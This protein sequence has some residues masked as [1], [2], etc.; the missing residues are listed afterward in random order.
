[1]PVQLLFMVY[2]LPMVVLV[3]TKKGKK[4]QRDSSVKWYDGMAELDILFSPV[5]G[6][7]NA[8]L[9]NLAATN[10]GEAPC[11]HLIKSVTWLPIK[12]KKAGFFDQIVR[13]ALT[14]ELQSKR[15]WR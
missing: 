13:T 1:M 12:M 10:A 9:R 14:A 15:I 2:V 4:N 7:Q 3:T 11:I 5:K 6:Y 8:T